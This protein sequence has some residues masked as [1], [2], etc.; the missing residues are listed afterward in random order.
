[1][2]CFPDALICSAAAYVLRHDFIDLSVRGIPLAIEKSGRFHDHARLAETALRYIFLNP[3]RWAWMLASGREAFNRG[4]AFV[5]RR[6]DRNLAGTN[7]CAVFM[8]CASATDAD[9]A[10]ILCSAEVQ[11]V[12]QNPEKRRVGICNDFPELAIDVERKL[13]H[14]QKPAEFDEQAGTTLAAGD[15]IWRE[16]GPDRS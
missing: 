12:A 14:C 3:C 15:V 11:F 13:W 9:A 1:M 8:D 5:S 4:E 6:T 7:S 10:T 2:N 16:I